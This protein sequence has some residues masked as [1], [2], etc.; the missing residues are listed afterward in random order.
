MTAKC[1][2]CE[3]EWNISIHQ[4][5]PKTGYICPRCESRLK[6]GESMKQIQ[7]DPRRDRPLKPKGI[8]I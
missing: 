5:I 6:S 7:A 4:R 8:E 1:I 2:G 3:Q